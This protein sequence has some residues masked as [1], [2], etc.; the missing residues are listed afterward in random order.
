MLN[1][2]T[3]DQETVDAEI[4]RMTN[5]EAQVDYI[6][7]A[8]QGIAN[9][10]GGIHHHDAFELAVKHCLLPEDSRLQCMLAERRVRDELPYEQAWPGHDM[11]E[12]DWID[13]L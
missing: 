8:R 10:L 5:R 3:L 1:F 12:G 13:E 11:P 9:G 2:S 6:E 4:S 7:A